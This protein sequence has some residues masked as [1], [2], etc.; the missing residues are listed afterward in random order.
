MA[1]AGKKMS[2]LPSIQV[3]HYHN[4]IDNRHEGG[5]WIGLRKFPDDETDPLGVKPIWPLYQALGTPSEEAI[6]APYLKTIGLDSWAD[7]RSSGE[8]H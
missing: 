8:I 1:L 2:Q 5:L 3:W 4:W 7:V 6:I